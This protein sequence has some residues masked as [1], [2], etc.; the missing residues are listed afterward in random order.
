MEEH[1]A[2]WKLFFYPNLEDDDLDPSTW[3]EIE[4]LQEFVER[5]GTTNAILVDDAARRF[6]LLCNEDDMIQERQSQ[7]LS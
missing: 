7:A 3:N 2:E 6:M 4:I 1:K 5:F